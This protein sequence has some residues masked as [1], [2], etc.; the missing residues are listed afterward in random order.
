MVSAFIVGTCQLIPRTSSFVYSDYMLNLSPSKHSGY[1]VVFGSSTEFFIRPIV[2]CV[3]D[4]DL[5]IA[6]TDQ[7]VFS[8]E[9]PVL[10]SDLNGLPDKIKCHKIEQCE[11]YPGFVRLKC[12]GFMNYNW[13]YNKYEYNAAEINCFAV[14]NIEYVANAYPLAISGPAVKRLSGPHNRYIIDLVGSIWCPQWP[15][16]AQGWRNRPRSNLWPTDDIISEVVHNGC[17]VVYVQHRS[18]RDDIYQWRLSFSFA[19]V[20]LLQSWTPTQQIVYHLLRFFSKRELIEKDCPK[21]DEVL[22]TYHLKTL[23]LWTCEETSPEF[24]N[25][26]SVIAI[27]CELLKKLS[28]WLKKRRCSNYFIPEANLFHDQTSPKA[29]EKTVRRLNEFCNSE[30]LSNWFVEHY[31]LPFIPRH[32]KP[33]GT[34]SL[35]V[36]Y[37]LRFFEFWNATNQFESLDFYFYLAFTYAHNNCRSIMIEGSNSGVRNYLK[38]AYTYRSFEYLANIDL[39]Y[40]PVIENV[41]SGFRYYDILLYIL[42]VAYGL[43]CGEITWHDIL[44]VESVNAFSMQ[45]KVIRSKYHNFPSPFSAQTKRF[46]YLRAQFLMENLT[47]TNNGPEFQLLYLMA[48]HSLRKALKQDDTTCIG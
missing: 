41:I 32:L 1:E 27:C 39:R 24:W 37:P 21:E 43:G 29:L 4:M 48:K 15:K 42:H 6:D 22:C 31:I 13:K 35:N 30:I 16:E 46:H 20:I 2:S 28:K 7:L 23:M 25:L 12:W 8:G 5:L 44:F 3:D 47:G 40:L 17:H 18:C 36:D 45:P 19:E 33:M 38:T 11:G 26:S 14:L 10:P 9:S 34:A